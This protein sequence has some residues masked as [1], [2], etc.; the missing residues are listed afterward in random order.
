MADSESIGQVGHPKAAINSLSN[1]SIGGWFSELRLLLAPAS[2][3][4]NVNVIR[5]MNAYVMDGDV[6]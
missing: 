2:D 6:R 4:G 3:L 1:L 5:N